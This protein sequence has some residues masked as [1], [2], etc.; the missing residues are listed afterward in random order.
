[1]QYPIDQATQDF[2]FK[3]IA[4]RA[5]EPMILTSIDQQQPILLNRAARLLLSLLKVS[6]ENFSLWLDGLLQEEAAATKPGHRIVKKLQTRKS[7]C[8]LMVSVLPRGPKRLLVEF[9]QL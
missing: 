9:I 1:M 4:E 2:S 8:L 3:I 5:H 7:E 6:K